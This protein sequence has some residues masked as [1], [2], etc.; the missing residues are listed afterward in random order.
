MK[1]FETDN[2]NPNGNWTQDCIPRALSAF[3]KKPYFE[4][5]DELVTIYKQTGFH[6]A[7]SVCLTYYVNNLKNIQTI[8][9]GLEKQISLAT[10]CEI[11]RRREFDKIPKLNINNCDR[12]MAFL[13]N[14]HLTYI[15]K[16]VVHDTWDCS[17]LIVNK[18][19][20]YKE[21]ENND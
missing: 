21:M 16:G 6:I 10:I 5:V 4:I 15:R 11:I 17:G 19:Y 12:V 13:G 8:E 20:V 9:I 3:L 14:T 18:L 1:T 7:D 2:R